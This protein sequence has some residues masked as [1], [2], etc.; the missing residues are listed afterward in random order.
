MLLYGSVLSG[1][2]PLV[3]IACHRPAALKQAARATPLSAWSLA[4]GAGLRFRA[5]A[6]LRVATNT[7]GEHSQQ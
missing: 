5:A 7:T 4:L 1:W 3:G 2:Q 6:P